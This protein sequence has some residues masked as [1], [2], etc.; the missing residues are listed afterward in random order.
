M[1][2]R[3]YVCFIGSEKEELDIR[4][5]WAKLKGY[6]TWPAQICLPPEHLKKPKNA[7]KLKCVLFFGTY[8]L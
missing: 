6:S 8:D 5:V 3:T 7:K 1:R 4:I 2:V